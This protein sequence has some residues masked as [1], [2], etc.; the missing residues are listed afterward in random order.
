MTFDQLLLTWALMCHSLGDIL[1]IAKCRTLSR[2]HATAMAQPLAWQHSFLEIEEHCNGTQFDGD[3]IC[4][5]ETRQ[6]NFDR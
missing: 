4:I 1:E 5:V 2:F 6:V 3:Q